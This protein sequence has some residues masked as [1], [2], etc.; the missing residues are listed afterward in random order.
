MDSIECNGAKLTL[1]T[2]K[3]GKLPLEFDIARMKLSDVGAGGPMHFDAELTN[4][5][6][7][8]TIVTSGSMGPWAVDDPGETPVEGD[9]RFERADLSVFKGIAG[10]LSSTGKYQGVLRDLVVDGRDGHAGFQAD[11]LRHGAAA[12]HRVSRARGRDK[13]RY[14]APA[15]GRDAG[16]VA[17]YCRG[18][19]CAGAG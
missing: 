18:D 7:P 15:G 10:I 4:P 1:E 13:W 3:P 14:V 6:P 8:G 5:R 9:Y 2:S 17:V 19:D 12:A 11:A 16:A